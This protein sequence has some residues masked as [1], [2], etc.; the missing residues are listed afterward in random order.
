M[1]L[2]GLFY[3]MVPLLFIGIMAIKRQPNNLLWFFTVLSFGSALTYLWVAA[4]WDIVSIY[5]RPVFLILFTVACVM[6]YLRI[7]PPEKPLKKIYTIFTVGINLLIII[8]F[9]GLNW[10]SFKGY[11]TPDN[12]IDLSSPFRNG[13]QIIIHGG[14]S[15]FTNAHY[16]VKPQNYALDIVG[17]NNLGERASSFSGD[18]SLE[19]YVIYSESV[20][21]PING[22]V[23]IAVD[24]YEDQI[25]PNTDVE[26]L[27][28]NHI[29]IENEGMEILLAHLKKGSV[30]VNVGDIVTRKT[31]L[32]Q[33]GN[34][35]NSSEPHLHMHVE[36]GGKLNTILNGRAV[37]F[38]I[39]NKFLVR[40]DEIE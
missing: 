8:F 23:V 7:R 17:I 6:G 22:V 10:F 15:P 16:H 20:Y 12:S 33:V 35:G 4:R 18:L 26:H 24:K 14:A 3:I 38:T 40:G 31:L 19:R 13:R 25:P 34:S 37:A 36:K 28:G 27:A 32:G 30:A 1:F 11:I 2:T 39:N 21:S 5:F 29:L 9:S